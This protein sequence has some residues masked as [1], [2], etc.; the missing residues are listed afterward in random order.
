MI[1]ALQLAVVLALSRAMRWLFACLKQPAVIG[2]MVAGLLLGPS[3][4]G[5]LMPRTFAAIFNPSQLTA[6]NTLSQIG[7]VLFMFIIGMR[8]RSNSYPTHGGVAVIVSIT[9]IAV[10]FALGA[11]LA[12][13]AHARLAPS[14]VGALPFAL[15]VGAAM[16]ITAFPVLARIL[17][18]HSLLATELGILAISCAA[19]DDVTGWLIVAGILSLVNGTTVSTFSIRLLMFLGYIAVMTLLVRR[20]LEWA[21]GTPRFAS[22]TSPG[23]TGIILLVVLVSAWITDVLGV[24]ALFGAFFAGLMMPAS[25]D[26]E[27]RVVRRIE[28]ITVA[29]LLPLFFAFT[30][31]RTNV[32][33]LDNSAMWRDT[34]LFLAAAIL[35]KGGAS[36]MAARAMDVRWREAAALGVLL[37]TRGLVELVILNIGAELGILSPGLYAML[38]LMALFTTVMTSPALTLLGFE[39]TGQK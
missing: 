18:D 23:L 38:V 16:S 2:E 29:A 39:S 5:W 25:A 32:L 15:F 30:G 10:P 12:V 20:A 14:H 36:M 3:C 21:A 6:L 34:V 26:I 28:P 33:L 17:D 9:S 11:I 8:V 19:F 37:N 1:L 35:G 24:H 7:V 22:T 31:L 13:A 27:T 4:F